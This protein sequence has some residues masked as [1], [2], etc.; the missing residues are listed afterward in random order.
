MVYQL[1]RESAGTREERAARVRAELAESGVD[2]FEAL[3]DRLADSDPPLSHEDHV[4]MIGATD[5]GISVAPRP[6]QPP[7][8]RVVIDGEAN[9][10]ETVR[11]FDGQPLYSTPGLDKKGSLLLYS[12]TSLRGLNSHLL[13]A[14]RHDIGT[15]NPDS[16][17]ELS[18]YYEHEDGGGDW[19]QNGPGRA[20]ADLRRVPRG[21][22]HTGDWN[23]I[24]SSVN[25]C[26]WDVS[27]WDRPNYQG[28]QLYLPAGQ[29]YYHLSQ[30]GWNDCVSSTAN[31]GRRF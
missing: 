4:M 12:F 16:L 3:V 21:F 11:E 18:Y 19:L 22:L 9:E 31:W 27:V 17:P 8:M 26:R 15:T 29:T 25:W 23:D 10:P 7:E 2:S 30:F 13:A 28:S 24:I 20:W 1:S 6:H 14:P 5:G